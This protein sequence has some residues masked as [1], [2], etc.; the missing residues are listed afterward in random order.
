MRTLDLG[1]APLVFWED[2]V[3]LEAALLAFDETQHLAAPVTVVVNQFPGLLQIDLESRR[4]VVVTEAQVAVADETLDGGFRETHNDTLFETRQNRQDPMFKA[5]FSGHIGEVV[6]HA[7]ALN[8]FSDDFRAKQ[9]ARF[10]PLIA[11]GREVLGLRRGAYLRRAEVRL[12]LKEWKE[13]VNAVRLSVYGELVGLA[14][15]KKRPRSF[16]E[17]FFRAYEKGTSR[18]AT[19]TDS[20]EAVGPVEG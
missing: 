12:T 16:A 1:A 20:V 14:A 8:L 9:R 3:Y 15:Q 5:L 2:A 6:R 13:E 7:L 18:P 11:R 4:G 19:D 17:A 10:A